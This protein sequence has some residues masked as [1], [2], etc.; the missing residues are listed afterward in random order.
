VRDGRG[1]VSMK[2]IEPSILVGFRGIGGGVDG[3]EVVQ[4]ACCERCRRICF[5]VSQGLDRMDKTEQEETHLPR[6]PRSHCSRRVL[7]SV[8][9]RSISI[10]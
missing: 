4:S 10:G 2:T 5:G 3:K 9:Y 6:Q 1:R 8:V 7:P